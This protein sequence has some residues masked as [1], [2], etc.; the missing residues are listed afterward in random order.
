MI[1]VVIVFTACNTFSSRCIQWINT[2]THT[3]THQKV[4]IRG[5]TKL[6]QQIEWEKSQQRVSCGSNIIVR[7]ALRSI[8]LRVIQLDH[9]VYSTHTQTAS[10]RRCP[11]DKEIQYLVHYLDFQWTL[12]SA[13]EKESVGFCEHWQNQQK[14]LDYV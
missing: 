8:C 4:E 6:L 1:V 12:V 11:D 2:H 3:H 10:E 5:S 14:S 9:I 7:I 13:G